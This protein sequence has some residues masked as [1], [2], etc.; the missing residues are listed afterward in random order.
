MQLV[1]LEMRDCRSYGSLSFRP[2]PGVNVLVGP[3]GAGKTSILEAIGYLATLVSFR[4][5]PERAL[6]REG[7][8]AA[9][10]RAEFFTGV[11]GA[12]IEVEIPAVGGRKV[13][14]NGKRAQSRADVARVVAVVTFL[15]D[16]LDLVKRGPAYRR[17]Y[18]DDVAA[19]AW[20]AVSTEQAE[21]E[22]ALRQR[23]ALLRKEGRRTDEA[24]LDVWDDRVSRL[25]AKVLERRLSVL[26]LLAPEVSG[27]Y[28][29]LGEGSER[30]SWRYSATGDTELVEPLRRA[31]SD[32]RQ[33][34]LDRRTTTVGPHR[35]ELAISIDG[36]DTR[37]RASQGEQ[38]SIAL[39]LRI[40][41]F[42]VLLDRRGSPPVLLLDDVF[43]ELDAGRSRRL[44]SH[45]PEAQVFVTSARAE[46]V[47]LVGARWRVDDGE[48]AAV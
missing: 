14:L 46:E 48:V 3:N 28:G 7:A 24:T 5:S 41:A 10:V 2:D 39:G 21:Y 26:E 44:V 17:E 11:G 15:P 38:R 25:G 12:V 23:N 22:R 35:D 29:E 42:R 4:R 34:D 37:T 18:I 43:S 32:A 8:E 45:L 6:V 19:Q 31:L 27:L 36:R 33:D 30:L 20:P 47:P 13:L 9:I 1:W 40:A 16:D